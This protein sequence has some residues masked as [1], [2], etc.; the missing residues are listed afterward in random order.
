MIKH[1]AI[2]I[3][4]IPSI[5]FSQEYL[6]KNTIVRVQAIISN[7]VFQ[8]YSE[9][10]AIC[11]TLEKE[12]P[13]NPVGYFFHAATLQSRMLDYENYAAIDT[14]FKYTEKAINQS[15]KDIKKHP[16]SSWPYFFLGGAIGYEAM[17]RG[18]NN[19]LFHAFRDGWKSIN[20]LQTALEL[21][22]TNYDIYL[23]IGTY[24][25]YRSKLSKFLKWLPFVNDERELGKEMI[26]L[27][28]ENGNFTRPAALNGLFWILVKEEN[29]AEAESL[30]NMAVAEH[31]GS[32]FFLWG[33][34]KLNLKQKKWREALQSYNEILATYDRENIKTPFNRMQCYTYLAE[35]KFNLGNL[36]EAIRYATQALQIEID[37]YLKKRAK[38]IRHQARDILKKAEKQSS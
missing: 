31:P 32:R 33:K 5:S 35:I 6:T 15:K 19:E 34:A 4:F 3:F 24:K 9:A 2:Y 7:T 10:L 14:F 17:V 28:I 37:P 29:F 12:N 38:E 8:R 26:Q 13:Q 27:A 36:D 18:K 11:D 30:I 21:D 23:G 16:K 1:L 25:Y 22:S 20:A